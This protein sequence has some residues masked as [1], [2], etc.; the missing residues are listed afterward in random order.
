VRAPACTV[1]IYVSA[2]AEQRS[3]ASVLTERDVPRPTDPVISSWSEAAV[4]ATDFMDD[5]A[6]GDHLWPGGQGNLSLLRIGHAVPPPVAAFTN[7]RSLLAGEPVAA[8]GGLR[9]TPV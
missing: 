9:K 1:R 7:R 2:G 8:I 3:G 4:R 5:P 6:S